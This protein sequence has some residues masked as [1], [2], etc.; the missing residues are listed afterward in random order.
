[1]PIVHNVKYYESNSVEG[2]ISYKELNVSKSPSIEDYFYNLKKTNF[3]SKY[4]SKINNANK[5]QRKNGEKVKSKMG[6]C[7]NKYINDQ[8]KY[9]NK[10][11]R[12]HSKAV[13][14]LI[15]KYKLKE[16]TEILTLV[17]QLNLN[18]SNVEV[19]R[20]NNVEEIRV[21]Q[22]PEEL[23]VK[24]DSDIS[25][26]VAVDT[27]NEG[28]QYISLD[29]IKQDRRTYEL[30][31]PDN[32]EKNI[33]IKLS[34]AIYR[35]NNHNSKIHSVRSIVI[36]TQIYIDF[37]D[38]LM[39]SGSNICLLSEAVVKEENISIINT[40]NYKI[41]GLTNTEETCI[42][43][44]G[45]AEIQLKIE[46]VKINPQLFYVIP[47]KFMPKD[48]KIFIG[49]NY[50]Y[51]NGMSLN[52]GERTVNYFGKSDNICWT[53]SFSDILSP[54]KE[55]IN[56]S[57]TIYYNMQCKLVED[58]IIEANTSNLYT[59]KVDIN[60]PSLNK[61]DE[62]YVVDPIIHNQ[63]PIIALP[64]IIQEPQN[65]KNYIQVILR[66]KLTKRTVVKKGTVI[67]KVCTL[68]EEQNYTKLNDDKNLDPSLE[69][70]LDEVKEAFPLT[71]IKDYTVKSRTWD[72]LYKNRKAFSKGDHDIGRFANYEYSIGLN[73]DRPVF[74]KPRH[75][76]A[77]LSDK[78]EVEIKRLTDL[79]FIEPSQSGWGSPVVPVLKAKTKKLRLCI[80]YRAVN[81]RICKDLV[82]LPTL[83]DLWQ[84]L[85]GSNYY[86]RFDLVNAYYQIPLSENSRDL[87]T[88]VTERSKS[89]FKVLP[90]GLACSVGGFNR[91]ISTILSP[92]IHE[93]I[94]PF[95]DDIL[96]GSPCIDSQLKRID[97]ML[98]I[99]C[100]Y[101]LKVNP[102]KC[103][104]LQEEID[105]LGFRINRFGIKRSPEHVKK[106]DEFPEPTNTK[107]MQRFLGLVAFQHKFLPYVAE[108]TRLLNESTKDNINKKSKHNH[109]VNKNIS[110]NNEQKKAF[111]DIKE[112]V[113]QEILL[114][115]P[116]S[117]PSAFPIELWTDSSFHTM[118]A[119]ITQIQKVILDDGSE[120]N[121][122]KFL[123][124]SST[125]F[126]RT[127]LYYSV[128]E[129]ELAAIRHFTH[130]YRNLLIGRPIKIYTDHSAL[131]YLL[132][133]S[134]YNPRI[135][136]TIENLACLDYTIHF[137]PGRKNDA[138]DY[139]SRIKSFNEMD[140]PLKIN[141][142]YPPEYFTSEEMQ[143]GG[144]SL[145]ESIY[146]LLLREKS[147]KLK[148]IKNV[149]DLR[150]KLAES[151][152]KNK[153]VYFID[154][155]NREENVRLTR[156]L[157]NMKHNNVTPCWEILLEASK[158]LEKDIYVFFSNSTILTFSYKQNIL[159]E[160]TGYDSN[161]F[162]HCRSGS[163][164]N[165][166]MLKRSK[167]G[168]T[169][170]EILE[171]ILSKPELEINA[172]SYGNSWQYQKNLEYTLNNVKTE[173]CLMEITDYSLLKCTKHRTNSGLCVTCESNPYVEGG[174]ICI[175]VDS[176]S[177]RS[178][179]SLNLYEELIEN[180]EL[181]VQI[182]FKPFNE[183]LSSLGNFNVKVFGIAIC[184]L[185]VIYGNPKSPLHTQFIAEFL[186]IESLNGQHCNII[187]MNLLHSYGCILNGY[188]NT[189]EFPMSNQE[190]NLMIPHT[191]S[192]ML[193][194]SIKIPE[195]F[196]V[197]S[198]QEPSV[199]SI[200]YREIYRIQRGDKVLRDL[201][202]YVIQKDDINQS[203]HSLQSHCLHFKS[204]IKHIVIHDSV[205]HYKE[206]V[207][208]PKKFLIGVVLDL[209]NDMAH[210]G[211]E[212]LYQ[213]LTSEVFY[214][215]LREIALE[216]ANT[217]LICQMSKDKPL[218][219][220]PPILKIKTEQPGE[221]VAVDLI[222]LP[223]T[224]Q[225]FIGCLVAVDLNSK[226]AT[227]VPFKSKTG[228][229]ISQLF[230]TQILN[231]L[232]GLPLKVLS[233]NGPEFVCANFE[234]MLTKYNIKHIKITPLNPSSNGAIER[235]NR[236][237][238]NILRGLE[239][240]GTDWDRQLTKTIQIYNDTYHKEIKCSPNHYILAKK[241]KESKT[242]HASKAIVE[243]WRV[244][245]PH[246]MPFKL[247]QLVLFKVKF[248]GNLVI[249]K[250]KDRY[251][252]P[253]R[254]VNVDKNNLS[255]VIDRIVGGKLEQRRAHYKSLRLW[256]LPSKM[257][258]SHP[259]YLAIYG[260]VL[261]QM[262]EQIS[263]DN[264][265]I[266]IDEIS[267]DNMSVKS[268]EV[269]NG[270]NLFDS[271]IDKPGYF[272]L[273][274]FTTEGVNSN[275]HQDSVMP[276]NNMYC[277]EI[278]FA[279]HSQSIQQNSILTIPRQVTHINSNSITLDKNSQ[280]VFLKPV[281]NNLENVMTKINNQEK[282]LK[283]NESLLKPSSHCSINNQFSQVWES[284]NV[285]HSDLENSLVTTINSNVESSYTEST[286][287]NLIDCQPSL[288][289][290]CS[291]IN[292]KDV[293]NISEFSIHK[294]L[295][296][297]QTPPCTKC[298]FK[299]TRDIGTQCNFEMFSICDVSDIYIP[300]ANTVQMSP[301]TNVM[302]TPP[303]NVSNAYDWSY[304]TSS[305][306]SITPPEVPIS[307][308]AATLPYTNYGLPNPVNISSLVPS[309]Q[310]MCEEFEN[311]S[312]SSQIV[313]RP[314]TR[315]QA[316]V[317][318]LPWMYDMLLE[319]RKKSS[320]K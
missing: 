300:D 267:I 117:G 84:K 279:P 156:E 224:F 283:L 171:E 176:G 54:K 128:T 211:Y 184:P 175:L 47:D 240:R 202:K 299:Q 126:N 251:I 28:Q 228:I 226:R 155:K 111:H 280:S 38:T 127:Q 66:D 217:C 194:S 11:I 161:I 185:S 7:S 125:A 190:L 148:D 135:I 230:E 140:I 174:Y 115:Y 179:I 309:A 287:G 25:E 189:L 285:E 90:F 252:G 98:E 159:L 312:K 92:L 170:N 290:I 162:I 97:S 153:K 303:Q 27:A 311:I 65:D 89:R 134:Q 75:F 88:F 103:V 119:C 262:R 39:D 26:I 44:I 166:L 199:L 297:L 146:W 2:K 118:A 120:I 81:K 231:S 79:G 136:R 121:E 289:K 74:I 63:S 269:L 286:Q 216:V 239:S 198:L 221:I 271:L 246:F 218:K 15:N 186:I 288:K 229:T 248:K 278:N 85:H 257:L 86:S 82:G 294:F 281:S 96:V 188:N 264:K 235:F 108:Y 298:K 53:K 48:I 6:K 104:I 261:M 72:I 284:L 109:K 242:I 291:L 102:L 58:L 40:K 138:A 18:V 105:Y 215:K 20:D 295:D 99:L 277:P 67:A 214:P 306:R 12:K 241:H 112:L 275:Y 200:S 80:D 113:R 220:H 59:I 37:I 193:A 307:T 204:Y 187:G 1:M 233:D 245:H 123:S 206:K 13:G 244:G 177:T 129:K 266:P 23:S 315:S 178:A 68:L 76:N 41:N 213:W 30:V 22:I 42:M 209:H 219:I 227:A 314:S 195:L 163:H 301:F 225:G 19:R 139:L 77:D 95:F 254:V 197:R 71:H 133:N 191:D 310:A 253:F 106:I 116:Q 57:K 302:P 255:Y 154:S 21:P 83:M 36:H 145:L 282:T 110:L 292:S 43:P 130:V 247:N 91:C 249:N 122:R 180:E 9:N 16:R 51:K 33:D 29:Q 152:A 131:I 142:E 207:I 304:G 167:I 157:N 182:T 107:Q 137:V 5:A 46:A 183:P 4:I 150:E 164:C 61:N 124:F 56:F 256:R 158:F 272:V 263:D 141:F 50:M 319:R 296:E 205:M 114:A 308:I 208:L 192:I 172:Y 232:L 260:D 151:L 144:N 293:S 265:N 169:A 168:K 212:K 234:E 316:P 250:L 243:T 87:T 49:Y 201:F 258:R 64:G 100:Q 318:D 147:E 268:D 149:Q 276:R 45:V 70:S 60:Y 305:D 3:K 32:K 31:F 273:D 55:Q 181:R 160:K 94:L 10:C 238:L 17:S 196:N 24:T 93:S 62:C 34:D 320:K 78:I 313:T 35:I 237:L 223:R 69:W 317:P 143:G 52:F 132:S 203:D 173:Q 274:T 101:N 73:D 222:S 8:S 259:R 270:S 165:P 14:E 236:S 210:M